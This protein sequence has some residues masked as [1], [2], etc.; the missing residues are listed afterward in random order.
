MFIPQWIRVVTSAMVPS[1]LVITVSLTACGPSPTQTIKPPPT[2]TI[3]PP[4]TPTMESPLKRRDVAPAGVEALVSKRDASASGSPCVFVF[5]VSRPDFAVETSGCDVMPSYCWICAEGWEPNQYVEISINRPQ[6]DTFIKDWPQRADATGAAEW[7]RN[8][9]PYDD[10]AGEY[11]VYAKQGTH[12]AVARF[13]LREAT[14]PTI[15]V[16]PRSSPPGGMFRIT[17]AGF[18]PRQPVVLHL[19]RLEGEPSVWVY[20]TSLEAETD[21]GGRHFYLLHTQPSDPEGE[22]RVATVP[23]SHGYNEFYVGR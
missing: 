16:H 6:G 17:L 12:G 8:M 4:P 18:P 20:L 3:K 21:E 14:E 11:L 19:F 22:Y 5:P 10:P 1:V 9:D 23:R 7:V 13:T 2:P 15:L